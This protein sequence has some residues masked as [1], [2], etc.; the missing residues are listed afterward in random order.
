[1]LPVSSLVMSTA[2]LVSTLRR[3]RSSMPCP[4]R[5]PGRRDPSF[6]GIW[7]RSGPGIAA[8]LGHPGL[9]AVVVVGVTAGELRDLGVPLPGIGGQSQ[10][11]SVGARRE[12]GTLRV[13]VV[14]V[15]VK[16]QVTDE[17]DRQQGNNVGQRRDRVVR[18]ER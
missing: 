5:S 12:V 16:A 11:P 17:I 6:G 8:I 1:M 4:S 3:C 18:A 7:L 10:I 15:P 14:A 13:H 2:S 9:V